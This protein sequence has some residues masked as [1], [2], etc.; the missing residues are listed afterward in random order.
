PSALKSNISA[1]DNIGVGEGT[2]Y[3][4]TVGTG[5]TAIG[6]GALFSNTGSNNIALGAN[7]GANLT[8]GSNNIT[9]GTP[10]F[11]AE[12]STIR[13]GN[14]PIQTAAYVAGIWQAIITGPASPVR[15]NSS[16]KLGTMPSSARFKEAIQPMDNASEAILSL[17]PVSFRYK[18]EL[19]PSAMPHFGL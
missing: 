9:I 15:V 10:S 1:T 5:N 16:G 19:D 17:Q 11:A 6:A 12:D 8:T 2:L 3:T 4:N 18:K 7:A 14:S 13:I